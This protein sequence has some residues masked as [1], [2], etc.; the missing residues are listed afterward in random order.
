M[1]RTIGLVA[2]LAAACASDPAV[3]IGAGSSGGSAGAS[4]SI[5]VDAGRALG[6]LIGLGFAAGIVRGEQD[7]A[8]RTAPALDPTR[9]VLEQD[10]SAP[11]ADPSANLRCR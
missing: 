8:P 10:C 4:A 5:Q 11:L 7:I 1:R 9:R 6:V 2:A 3:R